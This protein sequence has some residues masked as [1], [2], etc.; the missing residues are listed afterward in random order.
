MTDTVESSSNIDEPDIEVIENRNVDTAG[1][2]E[3]PESLGR[4]AWDR[5]RRHRLALLGI[6]FLVLLALAFWIG[7]FFVQYEIEEINIIER[8]QGPSWKHPFGT[9]DLGRDLLARTLRGGQFS[10]RI[11][12]FTAVL[13]TIIGTIMGAISG[14]F[15]GIVDGLI[16]FLVNVMLTIPLILILII[17]GRQ[18]GSRPNTV[19]VLIGFTSWL[20]ASRL[21]RAQVL[22]LK[23]MEFVQAA[24]ASGAGAKRIITRH[25]LPNL[26]GILL[27]EITLLAGTAIILESTL[28]FLGLGVQPPDT[29]LGTLI[30]EGKGS[31]DVR[32]SRVLIPGGIVT[33]IILSINFIGDALRDAVDPK[34]GTE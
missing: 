15:G 18:F 25:L 9:D 4:Q 6:F 31:I 20:R 14:Y 24:R 17:F 2:T 34:S 30:A 19:A 23:E 27:V 22:Q 11:A 1:L 13:A 7:P 12:I 5:F 26:V 16:S 21:V 3:E 8:S 28:S 33:M 10:L 32:P 29:T